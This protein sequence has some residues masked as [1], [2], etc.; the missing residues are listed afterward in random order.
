MRQKEKEKR[1]VGKQQEKQSKKYLKKYVT[2]LRLQLRGS[3]AI[4]LGC[5]FHSNTKDKKEIEKEQYMKKNRKRKRER[6]REKTYITP[7]SEVVLGSPATQLGL[8]I[9]RIPFQYEGE[10][11]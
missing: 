2:Q 5:T 9:S 4:H 7:A 8:Y 1:L 10:K 11:K 3:S 6:E